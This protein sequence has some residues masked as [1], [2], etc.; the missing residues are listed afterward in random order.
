[1][2]VYVCVCVRERERESES[3]RERARERERAAKKRDTPPVAVTWQR[4]SECQSE[5]ACVRE[6]RE[7][8]WR[9]R[10]R[11]PRHLWPL[12]PLWQRA[13]PPPV[14]SC[15]SA[16]SCCPHPRPTRLRRGPFRPGPTGDTGVRRCLR[17]AS[18]NST[19]SNQLGSSPHGFR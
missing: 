17:K 1:M 2:R 16:A 14:P 8:P 12:W 5:C 19:I 6:S 18:A 15:G 9:G 7:E 11:R 13:R 4:V 10:P 3:E